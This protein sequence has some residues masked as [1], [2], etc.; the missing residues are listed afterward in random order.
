MKKIST[1]LIILCLLLLSSVTAYA[2]TNVTITHNDPEAVSDA[3]T[4]TDW[5]VEAT[6]K[7]DGDNGYVTYETGTGGVAAVPVYDVAE[8]DSV[9]Y[10][11]SVETVTDHGITFVK[12]TYEVTPDVD[13]QMLVQPFEQLGY[14]FIGREI[15]RKQLPGESLTRAASKTAVVDSDN[16][17]KADIL[18]QFPPTIEHEENGYIGELHLD[19]SSVV[20]EAEG[21]DSYTYGY[22]KT[23]VIPALPRND[24][25]YL[26]KH[27]NGMVLA[28]ASFK[29]DAS[30]QY[31]ATAIYK[32]TATGKR[33]TSY[34]TTATYQGEIVK[35]VFGN[36]MYTVIYEGI[37]IE[38]PADVEEQPDK[39]VPQQDEAAQNDAEQAE[40]MEKSVSGFTPLHIAL[41]GFA[42]VL[43]GGAVIPRMESILQKRLH[44]RKEQEE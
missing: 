17:N 43:I 28:N 13:P 40:S 4:I 39:E 42:G 27:W 35:T 24:P 38:P 2:Q 14:N 5:T 26:D 44:R 30:G 31:T 19:A 3:I 10:P 23:R 9:F 15:L 18:K 22:T 37:P 11:I 21:F 7:D 8:A 1:A 34:V 33:P 36:I 32:G 41:I 12:K 16:D 6:A 20:T 25:S 29:Q